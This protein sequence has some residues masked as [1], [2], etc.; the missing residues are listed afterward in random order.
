[1]YVGIDV[2]LKTNVCRFLDGQGQPVLRGLSVSNNRSGAKLIEDQLLTVVTTKPEALILVATEAT[3][4]YDLPL[5]DTLTSSPALSGRLTAYRFNPQ[6]VHAF[7]QV[8]SQVSKTDRSDA[9]LL[10]TRLRFGNL[11]RPFQPAEPWL[12]LQRLTRFRAHTARMVTQEKNRFLAHLFLK[13]SAYQQERPFS[14]PFGA[15]SQALIHDFGSTDE[16][17]ATP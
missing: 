14:N 5:L 7:R 8:F 6:Q 13:F 11:P 16:I 1:M 9:A 10:A 12:P 4:F 3:S 2:S 17:L 15:T